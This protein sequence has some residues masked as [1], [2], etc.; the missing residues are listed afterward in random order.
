MWGE[1]EDGNGEITEGG[2]QSGIQGAGSTDLSGAACQWL[3]F[4]SGCRCR[5]VAESLGD[6]GEEGK[7]DIR[8]QESE[9]DQR[10]GNGAIQA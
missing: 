10:T 6:G 8:W 3:R 1:T 5:I 2:I 4:P 7:I 9:G